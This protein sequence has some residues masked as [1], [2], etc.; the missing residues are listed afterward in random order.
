M[1]SPMAQVMA[2]AMTDGIGGSNA[3]AK[4]LPLLRCRGFSSGR[5]WL[6]PKSKLRSVSGEPWAIGIG[7]KG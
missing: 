5:S 7:G 2:Y 1:A 3:Q 4:P 6:T